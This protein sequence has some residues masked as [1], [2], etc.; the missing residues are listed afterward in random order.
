MMKWMM[1]F[2]VSFVGIFAGLLFATGIAQK[3]VLPMIRQRL[4]LPAVARTAPADSAQAGAPAT[5]AAPAAP[6]KDSVASPAAAQ[7]PVA[8]ASM[9]PQ[10][11]AVGR[12]LAAPRTPEQQERDVLIAK[13]YAE[14]KPEDAV[15]VL[16]RLDDGTA[17]AI[18]T[19]LKAAK[20]ARL[21]EAFGPDRSTRITQLW[22]SGFA[23]EEKTTP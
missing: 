23:V 4:G 2:V 13:V 17:L 11:E 20:A 16:S 9:T 3:Q 14:M 5:A 7:L 15:K 22:S 18:V 19:H 8:E 1:F 6:Q 12:S 10:K 21:M